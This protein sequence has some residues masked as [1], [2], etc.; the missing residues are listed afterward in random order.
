MI[1]RWQLSVFN[2]LM[3]RDSF[4]STNHSTASQG[5]HDNLHLSI[6]YEQPSIHSKAWDGFQSQQ[7]SVE[8]T[9]KQ[10]PRQL[11]KKATCAASWDIAPWYPLS[12]GLQPICVLLTLLTSSV[13]RALSTSSGPTTTLSS[14]RRLEPCP[15]QHPRHRRPKKPKSVGRVR[16]LASRGWASLRRKG[17][18]KRGRGR[19]RTGSVWWCRWCGESIR[20]VQ[21]LLDA[22]WEVQ[23]R[24]MSVWGI[25]CIDFGCLSRALD[26]RI[27]RGRE[28]RRL[29][30]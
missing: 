27:F 7:G 4:S 26:A 19:A 17:K 18:V 21:V 20:D 16:W 8:S 25:E 29:Q 9:R 1:Q 13:P 15:A 28:K 11:P 22:L 23:V 5:H 3:I 14:A 12:H 24:S 30:P 2:S 6:Q 10:R